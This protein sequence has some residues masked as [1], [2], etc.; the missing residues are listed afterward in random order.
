VISERSQYDAEPRRLGR[1]RAHLPRPRDGQLGKAG[2]E[3]GPL[4]RP[5][6]LS[7]LCR[8]ARWAMPRTCSLGADFSQSLLYRS[9]PGY[10]PI[11][12][13]AN[14]INEVPGADSRD[15]RRLHG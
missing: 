12:T 6:A 5:T 14:R 2:Q 13:G 15:C 4:P 1:N 8:S 11:G 10:D 9:V 7:I 3:R